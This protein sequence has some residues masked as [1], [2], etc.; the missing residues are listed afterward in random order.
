MNVAIRK[1]V[2]PYGQNQ[3]EILD[4]MPS[5]GH[6]EELLVR[7]IRSLDGDP[8]VFDLRV[9]DLGFSC[10]TPLSRISWSIVPTN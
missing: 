7:Q 2:T 4:P 10:V 9:T 5:L 1:L 8:K 6:A 3:Y